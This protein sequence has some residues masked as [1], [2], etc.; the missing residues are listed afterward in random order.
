[1]LCI[2]SRDYSVMLGVSTL[3]LFLQ[4]IIRPGSITEA[5]LP[6]LLWHVS[7]LIYLRA[8]FHLFR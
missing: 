5:D 8:P 1:M 3:V 4:L 7:I 6:D 2:M